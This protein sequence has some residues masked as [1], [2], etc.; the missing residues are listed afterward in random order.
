MPTM[1]DICGKMIKARDQNFLFT[2]RYR[3][4]AFG[5]LSS[6]LPQVPLAFCPGTLH[7]LFR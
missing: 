3:L 5:W 6:R 2:L 1:V 7:S 4:C